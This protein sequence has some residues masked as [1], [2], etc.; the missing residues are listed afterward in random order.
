[1]EDVSAV[2]VDIT[3]IDRIEAALARFGQRFLSRVYTKLEVAA[4]RGRVNELAA[5]F[6]AKE[7]VMKALGTGAQGSRLA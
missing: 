1:M 6:A 2:G 4:C 5:R 3:E 7:A